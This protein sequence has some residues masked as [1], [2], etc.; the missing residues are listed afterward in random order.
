M[1]IQTNIPANYLAGRLIQLCKEGE[2]TTRGG[3]IG[4]GLE[5]DKGSERGEARECDGAGGVR[6]VG[7][8]EERRDYKE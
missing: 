1:C 3:K 5:G 2:R 7:K 4:G 8:G 6:G